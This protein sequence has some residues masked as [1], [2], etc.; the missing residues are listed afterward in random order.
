MDNAIALVD[1]R[2]DVGRRDPD[3]SNRVLGKRH[4]MIQHHLCLAQVSSLHHQHHARL[5]LPNDRRPPRAPHS[6]MRHIRKL[7][8]RALDRQTLLRELVLRRLVLGIAL[9]VDLVSSGAKE[10][11]Q[12]LEGSQDRAEQVGCELLDCGG[13]EAELAC[14]GLVGVG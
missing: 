8:Q 14:R 9:G 13:G 2:S 11:A 5:T 3:Q 12:A 10:R 7:V 1:D 6:R 4:I